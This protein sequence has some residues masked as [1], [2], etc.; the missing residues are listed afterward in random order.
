MV[1][2]QASGE[3]MLKAAELADNG[4]FTNLVTTYGAIAVFDTAYEAFRMPA[5]FVTTPA[6]VL[7]ISRILESRSQ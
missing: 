7:A 4:L 3:E 1:D 5:T 6:E 2:W